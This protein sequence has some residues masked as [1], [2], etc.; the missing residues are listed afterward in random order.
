MYA[1]AAASHGRGQREERRLQNEAEARSP[2]WL[3]AITAPVRSPSS[4]AH[5]SISALRGICVWASLQHVAHLEI[6]S[7][8]Q[9]F[10]PS[11]LILPAISYFPKKYETEV[12]DRSLFN[13][14]SNP[15]KPITLVGDGGL[16]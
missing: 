8:A 2:C 12:S 3:S 10:L 13:V 5:K 14:Y 7:W 1:G 6:S 9:R 11:M 4:M 16:D 15:S